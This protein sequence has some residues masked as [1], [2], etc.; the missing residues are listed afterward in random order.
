MH[1]HVGTGEKMPKGTGHTYHL[2]F[3]AVSA[4]CSTALFSGLPEQKAGQLEE[5]L[6][7]AFCGDNR[8][9][10]KLLRFRLTKVRDILDLDEEAALW[11]QLRREIV[12]LLRVEPIPPS[13]ES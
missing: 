6:Q 10:E 8:L 13:S 7:T 4:L 3:A 9:D 1:E 5:Y 11:V 2:A 12:K